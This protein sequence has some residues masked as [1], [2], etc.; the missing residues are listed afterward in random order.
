MRSAPPESTTTSHVANEVDGFPWERRRL[1][2][3]GPAPPEKAEAGAVPAKEGRG[4]DDNDRPTPGPEQARSHEELQP[5]D[6]AENG[7]LDATSEDV[8]LIAKHRVLDDELAPRAARVTDDGGKLVAGLARGQPGP[9]PRCLAPDPCGD[10]G[11]R[12][13]AHPSLAPRKP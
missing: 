10:P 3:A 9:R 6:E 1:A 2:W 12:E 5:V 11:D 7:P 8:D 4:L 13:Q